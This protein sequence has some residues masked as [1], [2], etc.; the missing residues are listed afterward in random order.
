MVDASDGVRIDLRSI[1]ELF[2]E[3]EADP[4]DPESRFRSEP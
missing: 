2:G 4:F 1:D 3:P